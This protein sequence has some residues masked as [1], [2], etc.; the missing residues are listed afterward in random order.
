VT[1]EEWNNLVST[2][3]SLKSKVDQIPMPFKLL[4]RPPEREEYLNIVEFMDEVDS[5]LKALEE[6]WQQ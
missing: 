1:L 5:R 3:K 2:I 6:R 4:Y